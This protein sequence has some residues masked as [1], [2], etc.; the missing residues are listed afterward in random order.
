MNI[1]LTLTCAGVAVKRENTHVWGSSPVIGP[2]GK[3]HLYVAQW[4]RPETDTFGGITPDGQQTGWGTTSEVAHYVGESP[5]GPFEFVRMAVQAQSETFCAPHNPT[6]NFIDGR[7]V[8]LFIVNESSMPT[9]KIVMYV[10]D[11]LDD[12]WRRAAGAEADGTILRRSTNPEFWD[13]LGRL[14][15]SNPSLI[16]HNGTYKLYFKAVIPLPEGAER[17][18]W[19]NGNNWTYGVALSDTLEGPYTKEKE[20]VTKIDFP[21]EDAYVFTWEDRVY[22]LTRDMNEARGGG[23]LLW[24]SE[25]GFDFDYDQ[26]VLGF[27]HLD[28]YIGKA[29]AEKL[30]AYRGSAAGHLERPQILYI[31]GK[32]SYLYMATGLGFPAPYGSCSYVFRMSME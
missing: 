30:L 16:K 22:M 12:C 32:P 9:Q 4:R 25:D 26:A 5:E 14:G 7:Y 24:M 3:V 20:R 10:A 2:D 15:N 27:Y 18:A 28:H 21:V 17:Q 11:T 29:E 13:H 23:G 19:Q 6:I 8:L 31:D 1:K